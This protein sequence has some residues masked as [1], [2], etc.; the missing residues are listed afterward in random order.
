MTAAV[1][2]KSKKYTFT[3]KNIN[4]EK[5]DTKYG[6]TIISNIETNNERP[7]NT[8][9]LSELADIS[10][11]IEIVSFLDE[12]KRLY[13]CN[14]SMI[15]F[16]TKKNCKSLNYHCYW[17]RHSFNT[18]P[19]GCPIKYNSTNAVKTYYSEISK[20]TYI[21]KE[22]ISKIK[23]KIIDTVMDTEKYSLTLNEKEFYDTDG[24]FCSFNCCKAFI[25]ENKHNILYE[26]SENLLVKLYNDINNCSDPN[27]VINCAPSWRLLREYGGHLSI[28]QFRENFNKSSFEYDGIIRKNIFNPIGSLFEEKI[29]F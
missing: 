14:V 15:D 13:Q 27:I 9:N 25:K 2:R 16:T 19:I 8:T 17:C 24:I 3:L 21:I 1:E 4:T 22:N 29:K 6:I 5:I 18:S 11:S 12:S 26:Q 23:K 20:D 7:N 28:Q 10:N